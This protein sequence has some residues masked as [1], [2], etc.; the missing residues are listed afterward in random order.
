MSTDTEPLGQIL[1]S[2][3]FGQYLT[4]LARR[5]TN[6]VEIGTWRGEGSTRCLFNGL[7]QP[8]ERQQRI[9]TVEADLGKHNEAKARYEG[10]PRI[11]FLHGKALDLL[12][13]LPA[14][15]DLLV[16]DGDDLSTKE[17]WRMLSPRATYVALDDTKEIKSKELREMLLRSSAW[18]VLV[19]DLHE[20][21]GWMVVQ[22]KRTFNRL[23]A[24]QIARLRKG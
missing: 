1:P 20:R 8:K 23:S 13:V 18:R 22:R 7:R 9:W 2:T 16:L 14:K 6:I 12:G 21:N 17:E 24:K 10:D 3:R 4:S 5:S 15:I 19:D 11:V